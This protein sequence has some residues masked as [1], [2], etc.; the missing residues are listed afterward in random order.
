MRS[1]FVRCVCY[2]SCLSLWVP[3]QQLVQL[4]VMPIAAGYSDISAWWSARSSFRILTESSEDAGHGHLS[5]S[6]Q[7]MLSLVTHCV[8]WCVKNQLK[9]SVSSMYVHRLSCS[10]LFFS[11]G[12]SSLWPNAVANEKWTSA[13]ISSV[14][15][16]TLYCHFFLNLMYFWQRKR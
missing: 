16:T 12:R 14:M 13:P 6:H 5:N 3:S 10:F 1:L 4:L 11:S 9:R 15:L 2:V 7:T 8:L